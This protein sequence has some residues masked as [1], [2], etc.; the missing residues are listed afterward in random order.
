M[1]QSSPITA[2]GGFHVLTKPIGPI[3]NLDCSYCFYLEKQKL[4]PDES[5]WRMSDEVVEAYIR[6]YIQDQPVPEIN[7]AWQGGEPTLLGV[8]FFRKVVELQRK[9]AGGKTISNALQTNGT[10]LDDEWGE[11]LALNKFLV[12]L[13]IDGPRELHDQYRVDK[14]QK[15]TFDDV[16]RGLD[17]LKKHQVEFNTLTVVNRANSQRPKQVYRFLKKIGS[18]FIQFI[19]LVERR[20]SGPSKTAGLDFAPPPGSDQPDNPSPVTE[21]SVEAGQYGNFL[22]T[23]FDEWVRADVG[24]V[25]VQLFDVALG[26]WMGLGSSLCVFAEKCGAA[27]AIEHNGDLYSCDHYVYPKYRLGNIMNQSLGALVQSEPQIKFGSDKLDRLPQ[28][29]RKCEVRFAC[30]GECP[31]HRFIKSPD[32]EEGLNYLCPAYKRF[33]NHIDPHMRTMAEL[34]GNGHSA[35]TIM[36]MTAGRESMRE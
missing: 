35:A 3:C 26:N 23:I 14:Q 10:L 32:G 16:M 20:A 7:F 33:F 21:W 11:F 22:C 25:F 28:Y 18:G 2:G 19:P 12:G 13:S 29:C 31:K 24:R 4:Y 36:K 30:N 1:N 6:Q 34:V 8:D 15:P 5:H 9:H 17:L 27:L